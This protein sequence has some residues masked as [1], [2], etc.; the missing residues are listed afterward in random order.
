MGVLL[1]H[2]AVN[3][4]LHDATEWKYSKIYREE[5]TAPPKINHLNVIQ[6]DN[7]EYKTLFEILWSC[8]ACNTSVLAESTMEV[9]T[10]AFKMTKQ[11]VRLLLQVSQ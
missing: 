9:A 7:Q 6:L 5:V 10:Y 8:V 1:S 11:I 4:I 3:K 2:T